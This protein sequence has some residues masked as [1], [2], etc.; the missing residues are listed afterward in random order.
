MKCKILTIISVD[1]HLSVVF[2]KQYTCRPS[3]FYLNADIHNIHVG[4][5][6]SSC[7]TGFNLSKFDT[8]F[9]EPI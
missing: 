6:Y 1:K 4:L 3:Y 5:T 7:W 2:F 8:T 9:T